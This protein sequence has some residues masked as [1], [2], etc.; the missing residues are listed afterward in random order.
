VRGKKTRSTVETTD[1]ASSLI[2]DFCT[3]A[4]SSTGDGNESEGQGR[5]RVSA[6]FL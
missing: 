5:C 2:S 3:I 1:S 6:L 4:L